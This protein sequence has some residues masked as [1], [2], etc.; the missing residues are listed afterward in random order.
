MIEKPNFIEVYE[1]VF[2]ETYCNACITLLDK[3][4]EQGLS[5]NRQQQ[6]RVSKL[7]KDDEAYF[8]PDEEFNFEH[9]KLSEQFTSTFFNVVC[10]QYLNKYAI[11]EK[12]NMGLYTMKLQKTL[13]G[14]GYHEWHCENMN[15][16]DSIRNLT[17]TVYLNDDFEAGETEF[18]YQ[19]YRYKPKMGDVIIFPA[20]F[21]HTHRGNPPIGGAKYIIT[22]W[23]EF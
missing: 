7:V 16:D 2:D 18:L 20:A 22:G 17:W 5:R 12:C 8:F 19:Q 21:T 4:I 23:L 13:P 1:N 15:R 3:C 6:D 9:S 11:L 14:Q 10:P